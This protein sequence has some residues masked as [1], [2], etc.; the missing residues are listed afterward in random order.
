MERIVLI[1]LLLASSLSWGQSYKDKSKEI[2]IVG[3]TAYYLG[4]INRQHFGGEL[5]L[6]GG[7]FFRYNHDRRW[8][9]NFGVNYMEVSAYDSDSPD[10]WNRNRNL[11]FKSPIIEGSGIVELNFFPYQPGSKQ[12]FF[13]PYL[14]T[15]ITYYQ[16]NPQAEFNG[17]WYELQPLGTEGQG[18][19][20]GEATYNLNGLALQYGFG[21]KLNITG[22][23]ACSA[24]YGMRSTS[25]DYLDDVSTNYAD[26][27]LL[28]L[29][30]GFLTQEF[31][32]RSF[33]GIGVGN[34]NGGV[35]RGDPTN[36]DFYAFTTFALSLRIDK[37]ATSCWGGGK[38]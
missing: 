13:S 1:A 10:A 3:G 27:N 21:F 31:S 20:A 38:F 33:E 18:T 9:F 34:G 24:S 26:P 2:G 30:R 28:A 11:H 25:T 19:S 35:Q 17:Q 32:D 23:L 7:V 29:E 37:K 15:G 8:S 14:F 5:A 36:N 16:M 4:E 12:D 22:R 6:G